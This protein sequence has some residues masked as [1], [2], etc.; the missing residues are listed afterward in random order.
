MF[1]LKKERI[2]FNKKLGSGNSGAVYPYQKDIADLK[3][4]VKRI[5]ADDPDKLLTFL[6]EIVLGFSCDHPCIVP[7]KGYSIEK[8][9]QAEYNIFLKLPRMKETLREKFDQQKKSQTHFSE[10]EIVRYFYSLVSAVDYLHAK[11]IYHRDIKL[12]NVLLD[13]N[14]NYYVDKNGDKIKLDEKQIER[15]RH[16]NLIEEDE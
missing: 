5:H 2:N 4:A 11:R 6:P 16:H 10:E 9:D 14:G 1:K 15:L 7:I 12:G 13:E 8:G 3:W